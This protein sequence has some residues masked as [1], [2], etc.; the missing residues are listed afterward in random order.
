M[1]ISDL[2]HEDF[3]RWARETGFAELEALML[4]RWD[5]DRRADDFPDSGDHYRGAAQSSL[6]GLQAGD[7]ELAFATR[8]RANT[9]DD[10]GPEYSD[11]AL[12]SL[13]ERVQRW[14][15]ISIPRW[16]YES[17]MAALRAL[18]FHCHIHKYR[19]GPDSPGY[20]DGSWTSISQIGETFNGEVLS[21]EHYE[22][23]ESAHI[24]TVLE[25]CRESGVT[26]LEPLLHPDEERA[27][28]SVSLEE[29]RGRLRRLLREEDDAHLW[30]DA[31]LSFYVV[32]GYDYH[33]YAGSRVECSAAVDLAR[34]RGLHPEVGTP[35]PW[36][37]TD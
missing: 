28:E 14:L 19:P 29:I 10:A 34:S 31:D 24:D 5:P 7:D 12:A 32:V 17:A 4:W 27:G 15:A 1:G 36:L 13:Y 9:H 33:L 20:D 18:P 30:R 11:E 3:L 35:A 37:Y 2:A 6:Y 8:L 23:V 22:A 21:R 26:A 25:M 16:D